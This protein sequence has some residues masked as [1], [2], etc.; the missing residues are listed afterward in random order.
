MGCSV[1]NSAVRFG[2][3]LVTLDLQ[4]SLT[5]AQALEKV[6]AAAAQ[7]WLQKS[8]L[9]AQVPAGGK[10]LVQ[11]CHFVQGSTGR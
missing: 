7:A 6:V 4:S 2:C 3:I 8:Q 9:A 1:V 11:V 5:A 10:V